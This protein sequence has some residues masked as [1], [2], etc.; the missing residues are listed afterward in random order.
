M[1]EKQ[2]LERL[3]QEIYNGYIKPMDVFKIISEAMEDIESDYKMD[4]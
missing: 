4:K 3:K 1:T 2:L